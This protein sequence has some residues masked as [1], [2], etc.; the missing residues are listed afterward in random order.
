[1]CDF[2]PHDFHVCVESSQVFDAASFFSYASDGEEM[3]VVANESGI[4]AESDIFILDHA[5]TVK[6]VPVCQ[7]SR[8]YLLCSVCV[9]VDMSD[10]VVVRIPWQVRRH[11]HPVE[12]GPRCY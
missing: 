1:M 3:C 10:A 4:A 12:D 6:W 7:P 11:P 2:P 9:C 5:I 8:D